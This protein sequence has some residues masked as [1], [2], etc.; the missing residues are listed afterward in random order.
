M[1]AGLNDP[2]CQKL[3]GDGIQ[4]PYNAI[5]FPGRVQELQKGPDGKDKFWGVT[6][7][8][9]GILLPWARLYRLD[10]PVIESFGVDP[11]YTGLT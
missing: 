10:G 11:V 8:I 2:L 4:I 1:F 7:T 9:P 5:R 6:F 3:A